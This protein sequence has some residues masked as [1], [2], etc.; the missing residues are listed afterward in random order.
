MYITARNMKNLDYSKVDKF[1]I[2]ARAILLNDSNEIFVVKYADLIMLPGGKVDNGEYHDKAL[3]RELK[4][5]LGIDVNS[6]DLDPF[7][8]ISTYVEDYPLSDEKLMLSNYGAGED[9]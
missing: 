8:E 4:E 9:S 2:K 5:K 6:F 3:A 7:I 1:N